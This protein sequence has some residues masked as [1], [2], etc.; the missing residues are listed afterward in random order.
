MASATLKTIAKVTGFSV[1][2]V[3]RALGGFDDVNEETRRIILEEAH[4]QGYEPNMQARALQSKRSRTIGLILSSDGLRFPDPFF[5]EF[6]SGIGAEA[7]AAGFDLLLS[8]TNPEQDE[9]DTYRRMGAGRRVDGLVLVRALI[10]DPRITYLRHTKMPF[11][12]FGRTEST[13]DYIYLDVDGVAAQSLLTQ[14]LIDLGHRRIAYIA[15][16]FNLMFTRYRLQGFRETMAHNGLLIPD[17]AIIEGALTEQ[18]GYAAACLLLQQDMPPSAIMTGNDLMAI[19]VMI[20]V[21]EHGLRV[22]RDVAVAGFDDIPAAEHLHPPL[23][24][25]RQPI[26]EIGQTLTRTLLDVIAGQAV[27]NPAMLL[28]PE[29]VIRESTVQSG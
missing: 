29:L 23:T 28:Q 10:D 7:A 6:V 3:S 20:A 18:S 9:L 1:T 26:F 11:V 8:A 16:P 15:P 12:V 13:D 5:G 24:T 25:I 19:G 2:T 4:R 17:H 27:T 14:H 22:G 21:R